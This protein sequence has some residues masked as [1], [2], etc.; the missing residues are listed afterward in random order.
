[1]SAGEIQK[2]IGLVFRSSVWM[3]FLLFM[4]PGLLF[5]S[6]WILVSSNWHALFC[7][8]FLYLIL[9][10]CIIMVVRCLDKIHTE[11]VCFHSP[12]FCPG[13]VLSRYSISSFL[14]EHLCT[15]GQFIK[16]VKYSAMQTA[17]PAFQFIGACARI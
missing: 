9:L 15:C 3:L 12:V 2:V 1:M 5:L 16:K 6:A 17:L 8:D 7:V 10:S 13:Y 4:F 14:L 11:K